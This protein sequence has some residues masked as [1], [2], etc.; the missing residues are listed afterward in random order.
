MSSGYIDLALSQEE[1][2][3]Q[4]ATNTALAEQPK[5]PY[6]TTFELDERILEEIDH[7]DWEVDDLFHFHIMA[8]ITAIRSNETQDGKKK[9]VTFQITAIKGESETAENN[10]DE[11][12]EFEDGSR[13]A[14]EGGYLKYMGS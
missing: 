6:C 13:L 14:S 7:E 10:E 5:Y 1:V 9:C 8:K 11:E 3:K 4:Y 2:E 12:H